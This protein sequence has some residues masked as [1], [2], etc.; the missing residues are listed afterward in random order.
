M[1]WREPVPY[2]FC[3]SLSRQRSASRMCA[4]ASCSALSP[5]RAAMASMMAWCSPWLVE[6]RPVTVKVVGPSRA[7]QSCNSPRGVVEIAVARGAADRF[8]K[9][10]VEP[11]HFSCHLGRV[12]LGRLDKGL[13][14]IPERV[15]LRRRCVLGGEARG[16]AFHDLAHGVELEHLRYVEVADDQPA[17]AG[18]LDEAARRETAQRFAHRRAADLQSLGDLFL[19]QAIAGA[20][21]A[22]LERLAERAEHRFA[23]RHAAAAR[24]RSACL[25]RASGHESSR[26]Q[27]A[28]CPCRDAACAVSVY[29]C[30]QSYAMAASLDQGRLRAECL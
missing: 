15:D 20:V 23:Q 13:L 26:S 29:L 11:C 3:S 12:G 2:C 19:T 6:G 7:I 5:S 27:C 14:D 10:A 25:C 22:G 8:V 18:G 16:G 4:R 21:A 28:S 17:A 24:D 1:C 30:I 9:G